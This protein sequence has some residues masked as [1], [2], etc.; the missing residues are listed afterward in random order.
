MMIQLN[1]L[2]EVIDA[3][4]VIVRVPV[5]PRLEAEIHVNLANSA[6]LCDLCDIYGSYYV[7]SMTLSPTAVLYLMPGPERGGDPT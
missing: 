7:T 4:E 3:R 6:Q 1:T 2:L 5:T